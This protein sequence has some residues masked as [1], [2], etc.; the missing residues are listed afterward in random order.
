MLHLTVGINSRTSLDF[1]G[2]LV[3]ELRRDDWMR[4]DVPDDAAAAGDYAATLAAKLSEACLHPDVLQR[5]LQHASAIEAPRI[6][7]GLP[8][9][10]TPE[11]VPSD[12]PAVAHVTAPFTVRVADGDGI[13]F[14]FEDG[15]KRFGGEDGASWIACS[16]AHRSRSP[17]WRPGSVSRTWLRY[18]GSWRISRGTA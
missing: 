4:R 5:Y 10:A 12:D 11:I 3:E 1:V 13:A 2:W 17:S 6:S 8:W 7:P 16:G 14:G 9:S 15:S 18:G